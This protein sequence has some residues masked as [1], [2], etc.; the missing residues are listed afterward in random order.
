MLRDGESWN[1]L[2]ALV[3]HI[4]VDKLDRERHGQVQEAGI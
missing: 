1:E 2:A 4:T 3:N